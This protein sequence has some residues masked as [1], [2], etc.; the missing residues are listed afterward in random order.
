MTK[1][2]L[3]IIGSGP[4]GYRAAQYAAKNGLQVI[5]FEDKHAGGVCLNEGCIPTKSL[6]HDSLNGTPFAKAMERKAQI[7]E[8]LRNG[9]ELLMKSPGI[10]M[11]HA[12]ASFKNTKTVVTPEGEEYEA[13]NIIIATGSHSKMPPIPDINRPEVMTS[14]E[15]LELKELPKR[16]AIVGAG[17]IGMEFASIFHRM[18]VEVEVYEFLKECLPTMDKDL[19]KRLRKSMEKSGIKFNMGFSVSSIE[20]LHADAVL[21]A[22]GRDANTK[23]LNL[24]AAGVAFDRRGILVDDNM[25]SSVPHIYAIG[26][27]NARMMLAHA[28]IF[29]GFRAVNHILGKEDKI[30]LD[31]VPAAVFTSPEMASVGMTEELAKAQ[32]SAYNVRKGFYRANGKAMAE[33]ATEGIAKMLVDENRKIIGCH[34]L[35]AH[36]A[37]LV[38]EIAA[39]MNFNATLDDLKHI[40]HIHP[41]LSEILQ[42]IAIDE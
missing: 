25:R 3:I 23:G 34:V 5:I 27:V 6:V 37:D 4:G 2:D 10:Q 7:S 33:E 30:R 15:L 8:Q 26:D 17:V 9:V 36:A 20:T 11:V 42:D 12:H 19:A 13:E 32:E 1:T 41:T 28:A 24:E 18:G 16:L 40:I 14:T 31:I 39:L 29:Q 21:V 38:Q 22:T 35:G